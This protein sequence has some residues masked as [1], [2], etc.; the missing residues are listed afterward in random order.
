MYRIEL[1]SG[2]ETALRSIEEIAIGIRNGVITPRARIFHSAAQTWLPIEMHPH[3]QLALASQGALVAATAAT[4]GP[5]AA[6][7][8]R[9]EPRSPA[10]K[11]PA[12]P[13]ARATPAP[14][15][16]A[17]LALPMIATDDQPP[18]QL[19]ARRPM[20]LALAGAL[21]ILGTAVMLSATAPSFG[22][23]GASFDGRAAVALPDSAA[24]SPSDS[25]T[26]TRPSTAPAAAPALAP[27]SMPPAALQV[28]SEITS[29]D[30]SA[31]PVPSARPDSVDLAPGPPAPAAVPPRQ[32][33]QAI[34]PAPL[35]L[36]LPAAGISPE[37]LALTVG[38]TADSSGSRALDRI[39]KAIMNP[40]R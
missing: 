13:A 21:L 30:S 38:S 34:E 3:Y 36:E 11:P 35:G 9:R 20:K 19:R 1:A 16:G 39:R 12:T 37:S 27:T 10:A 32:R 4:A 26:S 31:A 8:L 2:E 24:E 25:A 29:D 14:P 18:S 15:A 28:A 40:G 23:L 7:Q 5:G 33:V 6:P 22:L 17:E